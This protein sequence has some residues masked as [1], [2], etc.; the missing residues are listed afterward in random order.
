MNRKL[1]KL[2]FSTT[3]G[4]LVPAA[5]TARSR[6][7]AASGAALLLTGL[8]LAEL[9]LSASAQAELP[10]PCAGGSCGGG[11]PDFVTAGQANY[12]VQDHQAVVNQVGDKAILNWESFNVSPGHSV[13][14]QQV[15]SLAAQNLVQGANFTTLNR[16]W[17]N[18]P[19]VIAGILSQAAGQNA[20]I[21]LVNTNGIAFM[22]SSQVNLNSF[23][24][25]SLDIN[26]SFILNAFLTTQKTSPQFEG[27]GGFI[28]VFEGARIT[29]GSQGRVMLIAPTVI[30]KG[31]VEAPDGQVIAA[32]G[33]K[34]F[35]RSAS[36]QPIDANV[37]GL[38]VEVDSPA[39]LADFET[40]NTGV[41]DGKLDG[42]TV[43][44]KESA[45]DKLG[46][47]T[48][49]GELSTPRGNVTMVGYAVNQQ[50]IA[51]ATTSVIANGSVYLL[52]KDAATGQDNSTR[53]GRAVLGAGSLTE[54]LPD[55]SDNTGVLDGLTGTGLVL[56]SQVR[57]LGQDVRMENG[58]VINAPAGQVNFFAMDN[59]SLLF[60]PGDPF[61]EVNA[62]I[63]DAARIHIASGARISVAGLENVAVSTARNGVEVEL[64]GDEL[65]DSPVNRDGPLRSQK[66]F[67]D[68]NRAL[69]NANA[70]KPTLIAKDSLQ[71]YQ[72]RLERNVAERSTQGGT[73]GVSSQGEVIIESGAT[74]DLSGGSLNYTPASVPTT[75]L[76]SRGILTDIANARADVRYDGIATRYVQ[77]FGR[78]NI[79]EVIDLGQSF[80]YDPGYTEGKSA[81]ALEVIGFRAS[82]MQA[83][84][85]GRTVVGEVQ[86]DLGIMPAGARLTVGTGAVTRNTGATADD[87]KQNQ[88]VELSS[89]GALLPAGF[90][91]GDALSSDLITTL[92]LNPALLGKDKVANLEIFSNQAAAVR[93]ALHAPQGGSVHITAQG[94]T[95]G[96]DIEAPA[97]SIVL[98][99]LRN[100]INIA[101]TPLNVM[102]ADGVTL[103]ARGAWVNELRGVP[104][105]SG[106]VALVHGGKIALTAVDNVALGQNTLLDVTGGGRLRVDGRGSVIAGNG[107][108]I[109]LSG[110]AVSGVTEENIHGYGI[111]KGG[112]L[113]VSSH[114]IQ[115]GGTPD[116]TAGTANLGAGFF[117]RG[118]FADI[119]LAGIENVTLSEGV[120]IKPAVLS[121]ELQPDYTLRPS[122]SRMEDFTRQVKLDDLVRQPVNLSLMAKN[123][124]DGTGDLSIGV[125]ARIEADPRANIT[126]AAAHLLDIQG[127]ISAPGG[128]I[129]ATLDHGLE[130]QKVFDPTHGLWLGKQAVLDVSGTAL[131]FLDSQR[132]TQGEVL[133][134]GT[135]ALHAQ[136]GYV[137]TEAGSRIGIAEIG[138][139]HV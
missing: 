110:N 68:I 17:D 50:G 73:V 70:G 109:S 72:A 99:A 107:G 53:G 25:S 6:G 28:K 94:V 35:L 55:V 61:V 79:K 139:A 119:H 89:G 37:R 45:L 136:Y 40:A 114:K 88:A 23:T 42:Q 71:S 9:L 134:G 90:K 95:V 93:E 138:R 7:K 106:E 125:G 126:L 132:L 30:N 113:S 102:V 92:R 21:I 51:R 26:D 1:Y 10:V 4:I 104:A 121:L 12:H 111:G 96:A 77:D 36:A 22:G 76:M 97:G 115:I 5:E 124:A 131:T 86:R 48:N 54:V 56:P 112:A 62:P 60:V 32:A 117:E 49:L 78:W 98:N 33:T 8:L 83:D 108:E 127:S 31:T 135:V 82:V 85:Q 80:N 100:D 87:Y 137:V 63:S 15:E 18:D 129:M 59:P 128:G 24:A 122:G 16:V 13:Q 39:G 103:S 66:V 120:R 69:A 19:S 84:I 58:A 75:L 14:F 41:K 74:I 105:G 3:L 27:T 34:V 133:N 65:K 46:H 52:A 20:N 67:V 64:R 57:V 101:S 47:V 11:I 116:G 123:T 130:S 2:I 118:G 81:G 43:A 38:L 44:L 29:A 91:F